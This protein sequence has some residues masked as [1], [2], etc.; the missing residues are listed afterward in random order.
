MACTIA[1]AK[2]TCI[3]GDQLGS[4]YG[5]GSMLSRKAVEVYAGNV[6]MGHTHSPQSFTR[7]SPV[8]VDQKWMGYVCPTMGSVNARFKRNR[9]NSWANGLCIVDGRADD[10]FN[11]YT[12]VTVDGQFSFAAVTYGCMASRAA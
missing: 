3:H 2:L 10:N 6:L 5:A 1:L 9:P 7:V 12:C 8:D 11:C 4:A